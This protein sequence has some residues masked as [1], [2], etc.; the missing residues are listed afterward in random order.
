MYFST[1]AY[2]EQGSSTAMLCS[3]DDGVTT[4]GNLDEDF[5]VNGRGG[6]TRQMS[7]ISVSAGAITYS[8]DN[9]AKTVT[10]SSGTPFSALNGTSV[11]IYDSQAAATRGSDVA[12]VTYIDANGVSQSFTTTI[13]SATN[14]VLTMHPSV[15]LGANRTVT[16]VQVFGSVTTASSLVCVNAITLCGISNDIS[17]LIKGFSGST[18]MDVGFAA[19]QEPQTIN[20]GPA[21]ILLKSGM[22]IGFSDKTGAIT[23]H[24]MTVCVSY[25]VIA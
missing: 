20:F 7:D 3:F 4:L 2:Q 14:T 16:S 13:T 8:W 10:A 24:D 12:Q 9:T 5:Y 18:F 17:V 21:G 6:V 22:R 23:T 19:T 1:G 25:K 15:N 11:Q